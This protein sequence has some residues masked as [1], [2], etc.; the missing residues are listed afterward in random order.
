[1]YVRGT[2]EEQRGEERLTMRAQESAQMEM[3]LP[4]VLSRLSFRDRFILREMEKRLEG[5]DADAVRWENIAGKLRDGRRDGGGD[6]F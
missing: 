6:S 3:H 5:R 4:R 1:M 2:S